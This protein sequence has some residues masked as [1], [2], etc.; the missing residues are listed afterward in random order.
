MNLPEGWKQTRLKKISQIN[1]KVKQL[2]SGTEVSFLPMS[3]ISENGR[4]NFFDS[5]KLTNKLIKGFTKFENN[6]VLVAKIT[7]C[8]EN[9]KGCLCKEL[10]NGLGIGSTEFH[11]IRSGKQIISDYM[12]LL[13]RTYHFRRTGEIN[14]T[15]TA[16]QKRV[17]TIFL[18]NY[19]INLPPISEQK[20]I[21]NLLSTWDEAIDKIE[22]LIQAKE[23]IC[24]HTANYLLF[25]HRR[26]ENIKYSLTE[27]IFFKVSI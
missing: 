6:D 21:A 12:F 9:Y 17:P 10:K 11:V 18:N 3:A 1:P 26:S 15:G 20:A 22:R 27:S 19:R 4:I 25:G 5:I 23:K 8:F 14:M 13:T 16:G 7:P 24:H 2:H